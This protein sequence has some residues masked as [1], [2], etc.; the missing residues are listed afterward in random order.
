MFVRG[1]DQV[2]EEWTL[3]DDGTLVI[4][5]VGSEEIIVTNM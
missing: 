2:R 1:V 3:V 5:P 4:L